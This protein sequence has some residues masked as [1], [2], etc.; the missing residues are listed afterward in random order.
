MEAIGAILVLA[1]FA[2]SCAAPLKFDASADPLAVL[3]SG[4]MAYARLSAAAARELAPAILPAAQV[5]AMA[6]VLGRTSVVALG[7]GRSLSADLGAGREGPAF[8]ACLVGDYPFRAASLSLG[9]D[10]AWKREKT[11][12][13][14]ASLGLRAAVP[15]PNIIVASTSAIEPLIDAAKAPGPSPVPSRLSGLASRQLVIWAPEP[16]SALAAALF[17]DTMEVPALGMLIAADP[18]ERSQAG[19]EADYEATIVFLMKDADS[20]RVFR[21]ALRLAWYGLARGLLG[22]DAD[23]ALGAAFVLDGD[24]YL[25]SGVRLSGKALARAL[26]ALRDGI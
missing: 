22:E 24:M 8:Q 9:A 21:P 20:A 19:T 26:V 15:G 2:A 4:S 5:K 6:S 18:V 3:E 17:G 12:Y 1:L 7:I 10:P 23:S 25:A 16:F 13:F 11:G 14:N